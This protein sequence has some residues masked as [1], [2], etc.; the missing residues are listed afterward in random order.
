MHSDCLDTPMGRVKIRCVAPHILFL[1]THRQ[2]CAPE[3][4]RVLRVVAD[5]AFLVR[6]CDEHINGEFRQF[7]LGTGCSAAIVRQVGY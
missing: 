2:G 5:V 3:P 7:L 6:R 4:G 1:I